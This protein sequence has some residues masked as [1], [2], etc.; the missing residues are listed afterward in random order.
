MTETNTPSIWDYT[1]DVCDAAAPTIG[2]VTGAIYGF[3][4]AVIAGGG[5]PVSPSGI[6]G[7]TAIGSVIG[8]F[9]ED[10]WSDVCALPG[11][12]VDTF[13]GIGASDPNPADISF[14]TPTT[15]DN[16]GS[17]GL[18]SGSSSSDGGAGD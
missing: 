8:G 3:G 2:D 11:T 4:G 14:G 15:W 10:G 16:P 7:G 18:D 6:A 12:I 1:T 5:N 17:G 9:V 13:A